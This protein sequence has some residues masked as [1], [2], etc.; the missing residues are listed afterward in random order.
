MCLPDAVALLMTSNN[1]NASLLI[2]KT[3]LP[4]GKVT[5]TIFG[6]FVAYFICPKESRDALR[7]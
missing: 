2:G 4:D 6:V 1:L 7:G 5:F 3:R